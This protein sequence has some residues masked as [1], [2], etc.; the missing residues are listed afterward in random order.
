[1]N[2]RRPAELNKILLLI[3][4]GVEDLHNMGYVHR[5]LKPDNVVLT[6]F[7]LEVRVIDFERARL[8]SQTSKMAV[9]GTPGYYPE[10]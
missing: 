5:D 7:P 6:L 8:V 9:L 1:M 10:V 4:N 2:H 3:V